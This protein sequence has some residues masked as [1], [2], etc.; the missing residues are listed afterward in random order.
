[1]FFDK[2]QSKKKSAEKKN[3]FSARSKTRHRAR[4]SNIHKSNTA[5]KKKALERQEK[6][7]D[8]SKPWR[9]GVIDCFLEGVTVVLS[10]SHA[11]V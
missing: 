1:M 3:S 4:S 2:K 6:K 8:E 11:Q 9:I 5:C 10:G 7:I